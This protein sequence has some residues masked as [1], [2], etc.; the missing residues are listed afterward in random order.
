MFVFACIVALS[1]LWCWVCRS[2]RVRGVTWALWT[3]AALAPIACCFGDG[4]DRLDAA[5]APGV[6]LLAKALLIALGLA[7]SA[8][9]TRHQLSV[10]KLRAVQASGEVLWRL[11][12]PLVAGSA[13]AAVWGGV[14]F[15]QSVAAEPAQPAGAPELP[16]FVQWARTE[17]TKGV[18]DRGNLINLIAPQNPQDFRP[19]LMSELFGGRF[20]E[21]L[22]QVAPP[23]GRSDCHGWIFTGGAFGIVGEAL[24]IILL[25]NGY[26]PVHP[27]RPGDLVV[28]RDADGV[29]AHSGIVRL[30]ENDLILVESKWGPQACYLHRVLDQPYAA[31]YEF[32][33]SPRDG[34]LIRLVSA[35]GQL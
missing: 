34:H 12:W 7:G 31:S 17:E 27:P 3:F 30:V 13:A 26:A 14:C 15:Y 8:W 19:I 33:R 2:G 4:I 5:L 28:Y 11:P 18:T 20:N 25:D 29:V 9:F 22:V 6:G 1:G 16:P 23:D 24:R 10:A 35:N 21:R 32:Y